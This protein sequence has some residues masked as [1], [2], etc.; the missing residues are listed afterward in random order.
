MLIELIHI[1]MDT[2]SGEQRKAIESMSFRSRICPLSRRV[3]VASGRVGER[4][5]L[6]QGSKDEGRIGCVD[7]ISKMT[8]C[9]HRICY[10][11]FFSN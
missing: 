10:V 6:G 1:Q 11:R 8:D 7:S 5:A 2:D 3:R 9:R 4:A